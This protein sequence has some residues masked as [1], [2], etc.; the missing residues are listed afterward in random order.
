LKTYLKEPQNRYK[1]YANRN[2]IDA[3]FDVGTKVLIFAKNIKTRRPSKKLDLKKLGPF[4]IIEKIQLPATMKIHIVF[5]VTLL[6]SWN[7]LF[8]M[9]FRAVNLPCLPFWK[10]MK[11]LSMKLNPSNE[12]RDGHGYYH[13]K[14][15]NYGHNYATWGTL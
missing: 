12:V 15:V 8:R 1:D 6:L 5:H 2:R 9:N 14:W 13:V 4:P 11:I 10:P 7:L 3:S